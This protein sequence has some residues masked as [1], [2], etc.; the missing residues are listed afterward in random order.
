MGH[1]SY[2]LYNME[3]ILIWNSSESSGFIDQFSSGFL[4][5][6]VCTAPE[7]VE[8]SSVCGFDRWLTWQTPAIL[9]LSS[10]YIKTILSFYEQGLSFS[11]GKLRAIF[12]HVGNYIHILS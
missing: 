11:F 5:T 9:I 10:S 12:L 1:N 3:E 6:S 7:S 8:K 2:Q 4:V